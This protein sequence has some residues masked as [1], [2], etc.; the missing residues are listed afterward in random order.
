MPHAAYNG[1]PLTCWDRHLSETSQVCFE[2]PLNERART[3][4][5]LEHL[6]QQ[7]SHCHDDKSEWG[8]RAYMLCLLDLLTLLGRNDIRTE[9]TKELGEQVGKLQKLQNRPGV[10]PSR[11]ENIL[12][13]LTDLYNK[14]HDM[15]TQFNGSLIRDNDFLNA[16]SNRAAIPGGSCSFDLPGYHLWLNRDDDFKEKHIGIWS[17]NL[18]YFERSVN[19]ILRLFRTS[20]D[21]Q[22]YQADGGVYVHDLTQPCQMVRVLMPDNLPLYPEISAGRHRCTIRFM[23]QDGSTLSASQTQR[24]VSFQMACCHL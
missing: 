2:Q 3:F 21:P 13:E 20:A 16:I 10:D 1:A 24:H 12:Q 14:M 15:Q 17:Q 6:F 4:L 19:L 11:L 22:P 18:E 9:I 8:D 7:F 5:R 23:E